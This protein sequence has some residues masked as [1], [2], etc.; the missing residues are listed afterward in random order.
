MSCLESES[1]IHL[2]NNALP[3][4]KGR[5]QR[6][7]LVIGGGKIAAEDVGLERTS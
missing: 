7:Y 4:F 6:F 3:S 5:R 2:V 1:T